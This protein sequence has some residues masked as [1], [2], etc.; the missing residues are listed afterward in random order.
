[1]T[2]FVLLLLGLTTARAQEPPEPTPY[3]AV[4]AELSDR[5][6]ADMR[7]VSWRPGCPVGLDDLRN[8]RILHWTPDGDTARG[9]LVV[10]R[11]HAAAVARVFEKLF[12]ARFP[13]ASVRPIRAFGGSDEASMAANNT[14]AFLCR[15]VTEGAGWSEHAYGRAI[16]VNPLWNP[17]VRITDGLA[18]VLPPAADAA[19]DRSAP[20]LGWVIPGGPAVKAF[21]AE[22]WGWGGTWRTLKDYQHFSATGH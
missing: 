17:Y 7:G 1:M 2:W 18:T 4:I 22:G 12:D 5:D 3:F 9:E 20:K 16:D 6:R 10:H 14:S 15:E 19:L 13:L 11:D 8:V 21:A